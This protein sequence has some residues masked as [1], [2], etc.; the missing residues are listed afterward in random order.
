[1]SMIDGAILFVLMVGVIR[2]FMSGMIKTAFT[3]I[4]WLVALVMA[5][6]FAPIFAL[7][8]QPII[9]NKVGQITLSFFM[10]VLVIIVITHILAYIALK[11]LKFLKLGFLDRLGGAVLG[12]AKGLFKILIL[13]SLT[14]PILPHLPNVGSSVLIPSLLPFAPIAQKIAGDALTQTWQEIQNPYQSL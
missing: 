4:G 7:L 11:M 2:G 5:S 10:I 13:L 3:L 14:A 8:L 6:K 12:V 1:M 9:D